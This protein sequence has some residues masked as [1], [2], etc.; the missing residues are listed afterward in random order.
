[1]TTPRDAILAAVDR[2]LHDTTY[3]PPVPPVISPQRATWARE[4]LGLAAD[5]PIPVDDYW[6]LLVRRIRGEE[7]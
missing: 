1:M 3:P 7:S 2:L 5:A 4:Q 6:A